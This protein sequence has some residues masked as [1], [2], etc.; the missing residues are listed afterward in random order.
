[1]NV[2]IKWLTHWGSQGPKATMFKPLFV[3]T[4]CFQ[5]SIS[6]IKEPVV[7][8]VGPTVPMNI[9]GRVVHQAPSAWKRC[10]TA[11]GGALL[12]GR[13]GPAVPPPPLPAHLSVGFHSLGGFTCGLGA[14]CLCYWEWFPPW[15]RVS[16]SIFCLNHMDKPSDNKSPGWSHLS[17][18]ICIFCFS[19]YCCDPW[20]NHITLFSAIKY[21]SYSDPST[22][23]ALG[24]SL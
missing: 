8:Q 18:S 6:G 5:E 4:Y 21:C 12:G 19:G 20:E 1:M 23:P 15:G 24:A 13:Q 9:H 3:W 14:S 17:C 7:P 10:L 16:P 11:N 2:A 22:L